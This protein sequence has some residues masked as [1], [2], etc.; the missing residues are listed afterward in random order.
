[1]YIHVYIHVYKIYT[2]KPNTL[3]TISLT[4]SDQSGCLSQAVSVSHNQSI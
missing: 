4:Q 1:M 2:D 3:D